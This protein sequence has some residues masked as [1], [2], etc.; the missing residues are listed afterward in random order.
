MRLVQCRGVREVVAAWA[1]D[2]LLRLLVLPAL[3]FCLPVS[4][5]LGRT[6]R[7]GQMGLLVSFLRGEDGYAPAASGDMLIPFPYLPVGRCDGFGKPY[8]LVV[9]VSL[10]FRGNSG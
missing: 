1:R 5:I 9:A 6:Y 3:S 8:G 10:N 4:Y 2:A 7:N